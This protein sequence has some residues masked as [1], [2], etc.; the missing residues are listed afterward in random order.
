MLIKAKKVITGPVTLPLISSK[1]KHYDVH[2]SGRKKNRKT[3]QRNGNGQII[4]ITKKS[5]NHIFWKGRRGVPI[6]CFSPIQTPINILLGLKP[7]VKAG[8]PH[9][10]QAQSLE[11][12]SLPSG[13]ALV[14]GW[15]EKLSYIERRHPN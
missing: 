1:G 8:F 7:R 4:Y 10:W 9:E 13:C 5:L 6:C 2:Y 12:P 15:H 3:I 14:Q 11:L